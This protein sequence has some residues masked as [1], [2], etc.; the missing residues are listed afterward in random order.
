MDTAIASATTAPG[1]EANVNALARRALARYTIEL[2][3]ALTLGSAVPLA[4]VGLNGFSWQELCIVLLPPFVASTAAGVA[5]LILNRIAVAAVA[6][7]NANS[8]PGKAH[9]VSGP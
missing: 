1:I 6:P 2:I 8:L 5:F 3:G 9:V 4:G 7:A